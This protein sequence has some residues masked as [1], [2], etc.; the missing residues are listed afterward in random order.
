MPAIGEPMES[1]DVY[2][3]EPHQA[4]PEEDVDMAEAG[5]EEPHDSA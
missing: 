3:D 4:K 5:E 1:D 2:I